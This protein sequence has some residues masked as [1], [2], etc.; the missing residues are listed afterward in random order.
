MNFPL[1]LLNKYAGYFH[2]GSV[3]NL[4]HEKDSIIISIESAQVLPEW[5]W[6][7]KNIPFSIRDTISGKLH[8]AHI[9]SIKQND[10]LF[11]ETLKMVYDHCDVFDLEIEESRIKLLITWEQ[12]MPTRQRTD[13]LSIEIKA[14][15][16]YWENIPTLF[17][18][19]WDS[20]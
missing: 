11:S 8:L 4:K 3:R 15:K 13:M 17:D 12:Y 6:D 5:H 18:D 9:K 7:R 14:E 2:D 20:L 19:Y 1:T 10:E 16:I